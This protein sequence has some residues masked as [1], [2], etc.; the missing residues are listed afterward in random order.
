MFE[1][2]KLL[3]DGKNAFKEIIACIDG[4][5]KSI[6]INMFI[7]R[8]DGIGNEIARHLLD[9]VNRGVKVFVSVDK[10]GS[11]LEHAEEVRTSFFH[12]KISFAEK[13]QIG[14]L[15]FFYGFK[16]SPKFSGDTESELFKQLI[17]NPNFSLENNTIKKDHSKYYIFDDKI[18]I[19]GGI[20]IEDKENGNDLRGMTYQ[21]YMVKITGEQDVRYFKTAL[22][23]NCSPLDYKIIVNNKSKKLFQIEDEFLGIIN[24]SQK[25]LLVY[26]AYFSPLTKFMKA[27]KSASN[28]GV[29]IKIMISKSAN[30][31]DNLNKS[32]AKKLSK[33]K[34]VTVYFTD[35]MCHTKLIQNESVVSFGSSNINKKAFNQLDELNIVFS[36]DNSKLN[37][38][39]Q[40]SLKSEL[41]NAK[42]MKSSEIKYNHFIALLESII[43]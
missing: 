7:W 11:I 23:E 21:D 30:L 14:F 13:F 6:H 37:N 22:N 27:I 1:N 10:Y 17:A 5:E 26:M 24:E 8:D 15:R 9:A 34:N 3:I 33:L 20:N 29:N 41:K 4:A 12:K 2:I 32:T 39:L 28:R 18:V 42:I 40:E 25:E 35:K 36:N 19:F 38:E 43:A 16:E 31:Q